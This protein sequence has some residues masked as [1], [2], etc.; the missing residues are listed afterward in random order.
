M[1]FVIGMAVMAKVTE[2][3]QFGKVTGINGDMLIIDGRWEVS[4]S[5]TRPVETAE[6]D[7]DRPLKAVDFLE[8]VHRELRKT[9]P[10][11]GVHMFNRTL[12][13][14]SGPL[15]CGCV[16][17][18]F[19]DGERAGWQVYLHDQSLKDEIVRS[20]IATPA[21]VANAIFAWAYRLTNPAFQATFD[22]IDEGGLKPC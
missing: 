3:Y 9:E 19:H 15:E 11:G 4:K 22:R 20:T 2:H 18:A 5:M 12:A 7:M 10:H 21:D 17:V 16:Y 6:L 1:S 13:R 14:L 8:A